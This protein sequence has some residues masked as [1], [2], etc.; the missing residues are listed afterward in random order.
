MLSNLM[1]TPPQMQLPP[2]NVPKL[3]Q[4]DAKLFHGAQRL[5]GLANDLY[6]QLQRSVVMLSEAE[7]FTRQGHEFMQDI[8]KK[9]YEADLQELR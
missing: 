2:Q 7:S 5:V 8:T 6:F 4:M 9:D 3:S 1:S